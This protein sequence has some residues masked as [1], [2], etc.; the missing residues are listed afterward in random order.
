MANETTKL[1]TRIEQKIIYRFL[2]LNSIIDFTGFFFY[3]EVD[4]LFVV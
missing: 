4:K 1:K 3:L 2:S